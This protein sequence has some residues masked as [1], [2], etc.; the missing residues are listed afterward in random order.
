MLR[1]KTFGALAILRDG[2]LAEDVRIQ[3]KQL[4]LLVVLATDGASGVT[5]DRLIGLFWPDSEPERARQL[6][7]QALYTAR[8]SLGP[9]AILEGQA[10]LQ[11]NGAILS[12]DIAEFRH[13]LEKGDL[14]AAVA[15]YTGPFLDAVYLDGVPEFEQWSHGRRTAL[16]KEYVDALL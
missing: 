2:E 14:E 4:S 3:R 6:L 15:A 7:S 9:E 12:S 11:L 8:R 1:L 13:A 10:A 16:A 5:R